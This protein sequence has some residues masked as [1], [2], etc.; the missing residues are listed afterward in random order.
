V[1]GDSSIGGSGRRRGFG[2]AAAVLALILAATL[3]IASGCGNSGRGAETDPEKGSDAEILNEALARELTL[4]DAYTRGRP[5]LRG[6]QRAVGRFLRAHEQE[7]V[8][9]V[10]KAL[11]GLGGDAEAGPEELDLGEVEDEAGLLALLYELES[12]A[13]AFYIDAA[14]RLYT[15]AP[16]T[17]DASLAAG[18]AQHL[19]V[20]RQGLGVDRAASVPEGFDGG[21][22]PL[23]GGDDPSG[24]G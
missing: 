14:P 24:G 17:L 5:L 11:R 16:R 15:S 10:T 3:V 4:F 23:P 6:P 19:V 20:L 8:D 2:R 1:D 18:H 22:V 9:A 21:E 13:L 7:Y 12:A